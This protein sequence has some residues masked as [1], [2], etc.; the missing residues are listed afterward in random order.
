MSLNLY[1]TDSQAPSH[2]STKHVGDA[3]DEWDSNS[4]TKSYYRMTAREAWQYVEDLQ[5]RNSRVEW[6]KLQDDERR[7]LKNCARLSKNTSTRKLQRDLDKSFKEW[8]AE[9]NARDRSRKMGH[10]CAERERLVKPNI[11]AMSGE[12]VEVGDDDDP[13]NDMNAYF[14]FFE[15]A[16]RDWKGT[17][18]HYPGFPKYEKFPDQRISIHDALTSKAHNPFKPSHE[19][20]SPLL[21]YI[22]IPANHTGVSKSWFSSA[23]SICA[24]DINDIEQW[25]EVCLTLMATH[26]DLVSDVRFE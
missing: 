15:K 12:A 4:V 24:N 2:T 25:I 1:S 10:R 22:H 3:E 23:G 26:E 16:G 11:C 8:C 19:N 18:R 21:R 20:G 5:R 6:E 13:A 9:V 17:T 14:I 7:I